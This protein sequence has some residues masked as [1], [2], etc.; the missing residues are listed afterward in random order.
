[1][2][3]V[4]THG[5]HLNADEIVLR[6]FPCDEEPAPMPMHLAVCAECQAKVANLRDALLMDRGAVT[7]AVDG[8]PDPFWAAQREAIVQTVKEQSPAAVGIHPF[9]F[10]LQKSFVRRPLLAFGSLAAA[11]TLVAGMT[12]LNPWK[13]APSSADRTA[14]TR[15]HAAA[16]SNSSDSSDDE[17]LRS[18]DRV[19]AEETPFSSL[20]PE[21][22]S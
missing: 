13:S 12:L 19:L 18:V 1:M 21:G 22:V 15:A 11:L 7:G 4:E 16:I 5:R 10:S 20:D 6:V 9:P 3:S 2:K 17:L 8:L 14:S